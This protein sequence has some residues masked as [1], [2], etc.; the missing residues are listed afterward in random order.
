MK[1]KNWKKKSRSVDI[2]GCSI[3]YFKSYIESKFDESMNWINYGIVWD[4]DHII[5]LSSAKT[6]EDIIELNHYKNLKP[7]CS[8]LNRVVK[9]DFY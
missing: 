4:I 9:R 7:L 3:E 5:P 2:L 6:E 1:C 8:Y